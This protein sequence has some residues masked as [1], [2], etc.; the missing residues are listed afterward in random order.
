MGPQAPPALRSACRLKALRSARVPPMDYLDKPSRPSRRNTTTS[1][2]ASSS[3]RHRASSRC[4]L[5]L[6][7][8]ARTPRFRPL[9]LLAPPDNSQGA[10]SSH[11]QLYRPFVRDSP[12]RALGSNRPNTMSAMRTPVISPTRKPVVKRR[13]KYSRIAS[14]SRHPDAFADLGRR[15][16]LKRRSC[17]LGRSQQV[18]IDSMCMRESQNRGRRPDHLPRVRLKNRYVSSNNAQPRSIRARSS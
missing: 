5:T 7:R 12:F 1:R 6:E 3:C 8:L 9:V 14:P 11:I 4:R 16:N 2:R 13:L 18:R 17:T 10:A 15:Q